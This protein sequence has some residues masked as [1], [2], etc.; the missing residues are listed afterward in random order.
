MPRPK[1]KCD[2]EIVICLLCPSDSRVHLRYNSYVKHH[3]RK[4]KNKRRQCETVSRLNKNGTEQSITSNLFSF[5]FSKVPSSIPNESDLNS[6]ESDLSNA[7]NESN[8]SNASNAS[9]E[10][11]AQ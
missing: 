11:N 2:K 10:S 5:N 9:N 1:R 3:N 6:N 7:S 4:H 8:A